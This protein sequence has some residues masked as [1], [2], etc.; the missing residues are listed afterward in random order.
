MIESW[1]IT[2]DSG[3]SEGAMLSGISAFTRRLSYDSMLCAMAYATFDGSTDFVQAVSRSAN[4]QECEKRWIIGID[5]GI[6]QP[7]ALTYLSRLPHSAVRVP[8][9]HDVVNRPGFKPRTTFHT[10][11]IVTFRA[12]IPNGLWIGS[13]NLTRNA[14]SRGTEMAMAHRWRAP[15]AAAE[16]QVK[17]KAEASIRALE[18]L[19]THSVPLTDCID[20]YREKWRSTPIL[21][22]VPDDDSSRNLPATDGEQVHGVPLELVV[23][24]KALWTSPGGVSRNLGP[25]RPGSQLDLPKGT[26]A[27]F[28]FLDMGVPRNTKLGSVLLGVPGYREIE[29]TVRHGNN[30]MEKVNLPI[31][32]RDAPADGY[33]DKTL[34]FLR[35]DP[36]DR[37]GLSRFTLDP[38]SASGLRALRAQSRGEV[39]LDLAGS[40]RTVGLLY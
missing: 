23:T 30:A 6:T 32:G 1:A 34:V 35:Q 27:F 15:L 9:A 29:R 10:K 22:R 16:D 40:S 39:L 24:A 17:R 3:I 37:T 26:R 21:R 13:A 7:S 12:N 8:N 19:W 38:V 4:W 5:F 25:G 28:G 33:E 20:T 11:T 36:D 31:P 14:L 18:H 2:Q